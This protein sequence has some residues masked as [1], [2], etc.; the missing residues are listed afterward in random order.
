MLTAI[1]QES[2]ERIRRA[3]M[4]AYSPP[5]RKSIDKSA[6]LAFLANAAELTELRIRIHFQSFGEGPS[7]DLLPHRSL[8]LL[9]LLL[10]EMLACDGLPL[11][12][13]PLY[14]EPLSGTEIIELSA[15]DAQ[16][17]QLATL[18]P[19][20]GVLRQC[21]YLEVQRRTATEL[22]T[23]VFEGLRYSFPSLDHFLLDPVQVDI[24]LKVPARHPGTGPPEKLDQLIALLEDR[25][26]LFYVDVKDKECALT[27]YANGQYYVRRH[28]DGAPICFRRRAD[29]AL[30]QFLRAVEI[31]PAVHPQGDMRPLEAVI[32]IDPPPTAAVED[33]IALTDHLTEWLVDRDFRF[34]RRLSGGTHGGTH[35]IMPVKLEEPLPL[36]SSPLKL[37]TFLKRRAQEL[38]L[39]SLRETLL[40]LLLTYAVNEH[41]AFPLARYL[42]PTKR[43][44]HWMADLNCNAPNS[45]R[46]SILSSHSRTER[47]VIPVPAEALGET[48]Y[49]DYQLLTDPDY[50]LFEVDR[51]EEPNLRTET[52]RRA[53]ARRLAE[54]GEDARDVWVAYKTLNPLRFQ[55]RYL[56]GGH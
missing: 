32:D 24:D 8:K 25:W 38:L 33:T 7:D 52:I 56:L 21:S 51:L 27:C 23:A 22:R 50:A 49:F 6:L 47:L 19:R 35:L 16:A 34:Y 5:A 15:Q 4:G 41:H 2:Y 26:D 3:K 45:G 39:H 20:I 40:G 42:S 17:Q 44:G 53:N 30:L 13:Q 12:I 46:R 11:I 14:H 9:Q 1:Q 29:L 55:N 10:P 18:L 28:L 48:R 36:L 43:P 31:I 37:T 54:L